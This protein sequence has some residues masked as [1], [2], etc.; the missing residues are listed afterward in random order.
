[1]YTRMVGEKSDYADLYNIIYLYA[2]CNL[3]EEELHCN[4]LCWPQVRVYTKKVGAKPDF[5]DP[6]VLTSDRGGTTLEALCRQIH[7]SMVGA[8]AS[9]RVC[10]SGVWVSAWC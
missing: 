1:M 10:I 7:N 6:V 9:G 3:S 5:A 8:G 4:I 2:I